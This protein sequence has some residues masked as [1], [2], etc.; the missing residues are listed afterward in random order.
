M[1]GEDQDD[2][3]IGKLMHDFACANPDEM[4]YR[5][6]AE[7]T[8]Y[9]K[10]DEKG[11][12]KMSPVMEELVAEEK[13]AQA[14]EFAMNLLEMGK[15]TYEEIAAAAKLP[16]NKVRELAEQLQVAAK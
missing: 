8:R 16:E 10:Q 6:L 15:M 3:D 13:A 14:E 9:Y 7:K 1:N 2:S 11:V 4:K 5:L 12:K